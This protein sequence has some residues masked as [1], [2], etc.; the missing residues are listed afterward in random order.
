MGSGALM[1]RHADTPQSESVFGRYA[2]ASKL[3]NVL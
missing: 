1:Q 3:D 2:S